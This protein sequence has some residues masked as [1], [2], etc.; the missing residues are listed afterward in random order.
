MKDLKIYVVYVGY[1]T[2][3]VAQERGSISFDS[4]ETDDS[5]IS[6]SLSRAIK[7][8]NIDELKL[9]KEIISLSAKDKVSGKKH[10]KSYKK[11][12][13]SYDFKLVAVNKQDI[14]GMKV[15]AVD[16]KT[17]E[18]IVPSLSNEKYNLYLMRKGSRLDFVYEL[19]PNEVENISLWYDSIKPN[20]KSKT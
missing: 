18:E 6:L 10:K 9:I 11:N 19:S 3:H 14:P 20:V 17:N 4:K 13:K 15:S 8:K 16:L 1:N 2:G 5:F 7:E 12:A